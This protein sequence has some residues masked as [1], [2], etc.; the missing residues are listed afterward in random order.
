MTKAQRLWVK[1][2]DTPRYKIGD[3][4][5]LKGKN[6]QMQYPTRKFRACRY[7]PLKVIQVMSPIN[8]CL[9]LPTKW[10]IHPVFHTDLLTLYTEMEIHRPNYSRPVPMLT[11]GQEEYKIECVIN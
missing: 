11:D 10:S 7:G 2:H 3:Q 6:L 1:H 4:V 9:E 5:W 8:Y